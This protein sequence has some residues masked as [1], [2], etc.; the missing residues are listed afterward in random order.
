MEHVDLLLGLL[1]AVA[2]LTVLARKIKVPFPILFVIGGL[3][4]ALIPGLPRVKL[5]PDLV[6]FLFLPPLLFPAALFTSWRDFYA[7]I[8]SISLLAVGLV[9][10]TTVVVGFLAHYLVEGLP[11]G[12]AF[13]F[14]A[15]VSPPDAVAATAIAQRLGMPRRIVTVLEGESLVNDASALVA[16]RFAVAAMVSGSFS[17]VQAGGAFVLVSMGGIAIGLGI[18]WVSVKISKW[19]DDPPVQIIISLLTPFAAYLSAER[20]GVSGVLGVV[21]AGLYVGWHMPEISDAKTRLLA[22]P[23]WEMVVFLLNG[24]IFLLI[25]LQLPEVLQTLEGQS[26]LKLCGQ[27][28]LLSLAVILVRIVWVFPATYLPRYF[29]QALRQRDP[30]PGWRNVSIVAWTGMRGVV[31]LAAALGLPFTLANGKPFPG[32][33]SIIFF[34]FCVIVA[35]LVFQGLTLPALIRALK[36][37]SDNLA[38][39]EEREARLKANQAAMTRLKELGKED[40]VPNE[41][42][43][44]LH[45]E[46]EDRIKELHVCSLEA[47]EER[48][49]SGL[50][51]Y[52]RL[53]DEALKVERQVILNLRNQRVINDEVM[54]RI[55]RDL[56]LA[57]TRL[58]LEQQ[59]H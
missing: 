59:T 33:D 56:D 16:L 50:S 49:T 54:R 45:R 47:P 32:R 22:Y 38:E 36:V 41:L 39:Q 19:I 3:L 46:Y 30:Y 20:L 31:S 25:G 5:R 9:I 11:L 4:L 27:A 15:I 28:A 57:E 18:G 17:L 55:E 40:S 44:R 24:I 6:F 7:N 51:P 26:M 2:A 14:G 48:P 53:Q 13:A 1:V 58:H 29:S 34:T 52:L 37:S 12:A 42:V 10:F 8:R 21:T 43:D 35:T 23:F